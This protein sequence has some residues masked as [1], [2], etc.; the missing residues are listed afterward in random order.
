MSDPL[1]AQLRGACPVPLAIVGVGNPMRGDDGFGPAVLAALP[2]LPGVS[3]FDAGMAP[4]NWL[5]PIA[6]AEPRCILVLDAADFGAPPGTLRLARGGELEAVGASTHGLPLGFFVK[7][8]EDRCGAPAL[9][10]L[11]QP[12]R[13]ALGDPLSDAMTAAVRRAA[14][15]IVAAIG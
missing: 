7:L 12:E 8:A 11:A 5:G 9:A 14:R 13:L 15:V 3:C 10:L 6:R 2:E 1:A 4:E